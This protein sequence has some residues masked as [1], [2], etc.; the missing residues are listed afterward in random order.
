MICPT[1]HFMTGLKPVVFD[2]FNRHTW[3]N[4]D[5]TEETPHEKPTDIVFL[6][7]SGSIAESYIYMADD[8]RIELAHKYCIIEDL[9]SWVSKEQALEVL[10]G[11]EDGAVD[12]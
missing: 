12:E 10:F 7:H 6:T 8:T 3:P 1:E 11:I 9:H 4:P 2:Y 5:M